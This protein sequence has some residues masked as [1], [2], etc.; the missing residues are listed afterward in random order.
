MEWD[1]ITEKW[2]VMIR[3]LCHDDPGAARQTAAPRD[4]APAAQPVASTLAPLVSASPDP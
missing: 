2:A 1:Q 3:R 4:E